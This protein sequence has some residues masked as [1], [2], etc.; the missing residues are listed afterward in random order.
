MSYDEETLELY[1]NFVLERHLI[2]QRR[3][4]NE[5][6]PWTTDPVLANRKFTNMFRVLDPGSQFVFQLKATDPIDTIARLVFYRITNLPKTWYAM[7]N[8]LAGRWPVATDFTATHE[9]LLHNLCRYRDAGNRVFS[10]AY[11]IIPEPGTKNDKVEGAFRVT[12]RFVKEK[13]LDFLDAKTSDDRF[14]VLR[15]TP[16][17]GRFLSMQ[18]LADWDYLQPFHPDLS[19]VVAGPGAQRGAALLNPDLSPEE[20]IYDMAIDWADHPIVQVRG[21][22]LTPMDVQNTMCEFGKYVKETVTPRK[23]TPYKAS[24]PG[25][26]PKPILPKWW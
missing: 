1:Q 23:T 14:Q 6:G 18:I 13:A 4:D 24:H 7:K 11:I 26:Q 10:G 21:R 20:V 9:S 19:F 17:L 16:G 3:Q 22:S 8:V 25:A 2:W 15:S 12:R 5:P